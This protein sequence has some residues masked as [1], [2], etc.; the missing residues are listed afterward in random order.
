MIGAKI[1]G[2]RYADFLHALRTYDTAVMQKTAKDGSFARLGYVGVFRFSNLEIG[3]SGAV[4]LKI[5]ERL[6]LRPAT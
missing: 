2:K 1:D 4:D 3:E 6:A 5:V